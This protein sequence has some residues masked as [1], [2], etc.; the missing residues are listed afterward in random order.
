MFLFCCCLY[1]WLTVVALVVEVGGD[2]VVDAVPDTPPGASDYLVVVT[3]SRHR[4]PPLTC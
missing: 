3:H 4:H 2:V 1:C